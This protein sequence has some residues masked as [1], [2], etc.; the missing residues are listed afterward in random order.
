MKANPVAWVGK[1]LSDVDGLLAAAELTP[2][3]IGEHDAEEL[4]AAIPDILDAV[5]R[6]L[7]RV[8]AGELARAPGDDVDSARLSWL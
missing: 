1:Y 3:D 2:D 4:R 6:L 5:R 7:D 8:R